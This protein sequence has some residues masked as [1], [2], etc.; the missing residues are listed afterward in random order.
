VT[1]SKT[2]SRR[3][4][5]PAKILVR[6]YLVFSV[7]TPSKSSSNSLQIQRTKGRVLPLEPL[8]PHYSDTIHE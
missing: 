6:V 2:A 3:Y 7:A 5:R 1:V 8:H 4:L